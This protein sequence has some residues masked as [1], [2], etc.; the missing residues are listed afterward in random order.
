MEATPPTMVAEPR[1]ASSAEGVQ[2]RDQLDQL[3]RIHADAGQDDVACTVNTRRKTLRKEL[4]SS[5]ERSFQ[6]LLRKI[7][8][9]AEMQQS[10]NRGS[11]AGFFRNG[12]FMKASARRLAGHW[13]YDLF[14]ASA[15]LCHCVVLVVIADSAEAVQNLPAQTISWICM[16]FF[17]LDLI[18]RLVAAKD[19]NFWRQSSVLLD[20]FLVTSSIVELILSSATDV[21]G[22]GHF[23]FASFRLMRLLLMFNGRRFLGDRIAHASSVVIMCFGA[24]KR[25]VLGVLACICTSWAVFAVAWSQAFSKDDVLPYFR[26]FSESFYTQVLVSTGGLNWSRRIMEPLQRSNDAVL[27]VKSVLVLIFFFFIIAAQLHEKDVDNERVT[28][29]MPGIEIIQQILSELVKEEHSEE[30]ATLEEAHLPDRH[31]LKAKLE[32]KEAELQECM[33]S[34]K[35]VLLLYDSHYRPEDD[36]HMQITCSEFLFHLVRASHPSDSSSK[37]MLEVEHLQRLCIL[38]VEG[39]DSEMDSKIKR[40]MQELSEMK[41]RAQRLKSDIGELSRNVRAAQEEISKQVQVVEEQYQKCQKDET[42]KRIVRDLQEK[43][44][45]HRERQELH[46]KIAALR[47]EAAWIRQQRLQAAV[48]GLFEDCGPSPA[49][50]SAECVAE[51]AGRGQTAMDTEKFRCAAEKLREAVRQKLN[52]PVLKKRLETEFERVS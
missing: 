41:S 50:Q 27:I 6:E 18:I 33:I 12:R 36:E 28:A 35:E 17:V 2:H 42:E 7:A 19:R 51:D 9:H 30:T 11:N 45:L 48:F 8:F 34:V 16:G 1:A 26:T 43:E 40:C 31:E 52:D 10:D 14:R 44:H 24:T 20:I 39:A 13:A 25:V 37:D 22:K 23:L 3:E 47:K 15:I 4:T 21:V 5:D 29:M 49:G 38:A 46:K 32:E